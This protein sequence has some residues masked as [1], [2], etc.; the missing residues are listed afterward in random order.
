MTYPPNPPPG[1][2]S[3]PPEPPA[4]G[5]HD[6]YAAPDY[7]GQQPPVSGP[8]TGYYPND[9]YSQP[10][11]H[12]PVSA[13][14]VFLQQAYG[15]PQ[16]HNSGLSTGGI[17]GAI[18]AAVAVVGLLTVGI[19]LV[20]NSGDSDDS[21]SSASDSKT[22]ASDASDDADAVNPNAAISGDGTYMV[23]DDIE[24]GDYT[25]TVPDDSTMCYWERLSGASGEFEDIIANDIADAGE[26][27]RVTI[28][29]GD[30]A[31]STS[32]CGAWDTA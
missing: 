32:G 21:D 27:V 13:P 2:W 14:P 1:D 28:E 7:A 31:F 29:D 23:G 3:P 26:Q 5:P 9:P 24:A 18:A 22:E 25:A 20:I 17:V 19:I 4:Q 8:P 16:Q 15:P 12:G 10:A 30:E 6:P 11:D